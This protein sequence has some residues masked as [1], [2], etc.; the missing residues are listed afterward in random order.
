MLNE[1]SEEAHQVV[2][3]GLLAR[4]FYTS[5]P[6]GEFHRLSASFHALHN[7]ATSVIHAHGN[8]STTAYQE[9]TSRIAISVE[10][11]PFYQLPKSRVL[12]GLPIP[13]T[14]IYE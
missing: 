3:L 11:L 2:A 12:P 7:V 9:N 1:S 13:V 6:L 5:E 10:V 8:V 4:I 14:G